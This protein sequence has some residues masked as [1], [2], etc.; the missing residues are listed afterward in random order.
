MLEPQLHYVRASRIGLFLLCC[1]TTVNWIQC[2]V[3]AW[4]T[5][6]KDLDLSVAI[7]LSL[8]TLL[9]VILFI[10]FVAAIPVHAYKYP[11]WSL[12]LNDLKRLHRELCRFTWYLY[13]LLWAHLGFDLLCWLI[14]HEHPLNFLVVLGIHA[15]LRVS[16]WYTVSSLREH[17]YRFLLFVSK[18]ALPS[19]LART[20]SYCIQTVRLH[21]YAL[22]WS[23]AMFV[24]LATQVTIDMDWIPIGSGIVLLLFTE[25]YQ[26][27]VTYGTL[28]TYRSLFY[29]THVELQYAMY[30]RTFT[31]PCRRK[32]YSHYTWDQKQLYVHLMQDWSELF[33]HPERMILEGSSCEEEPHEENQIHK[34]EGVFSKLARTY[35]YTD[36][37]YVDIHALIEYLLPQRNAYIASLSSSPTIHARYCTSSNYT[38]VS[39]YVHV[40]RFLS[41]VTT[42]FL[43]HTFAPEAYDILVLSMASVYLA[44]MMLRFG[45]LAFVCTRSWEEMQRITLYLVYGLFWIFQLSRIQWSWFY[46]SFASLY[47]CTILLWIPY[48]LRKKRAVDRSI[49]AGGTELHVYTEKHIYEVETRIL[50]L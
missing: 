28:H 34:G 35:T 8:Q 45:L 41:E 37:V 10:Y 30:V 36:G 49:Q 50:W 9:S 15:L 32:L 23:A 27:F 11:S 1:A 17:I 12:P 24:V 18:D 26:T 3:H 47:M 42:V 4:K 46:I 13:V 14:R 20:A 48:V 38:T 33:L 25:M 5:S 6:V 16:I 19:L 43:V 31:A 7:V 21:L 29:K 2:I 22:F 39:W 40:A 44:W